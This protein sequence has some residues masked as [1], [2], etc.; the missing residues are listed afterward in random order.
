[1]EM[2]PPDL[3]DPAQRA[4]YRRELLG[5]ARPI[6]YLGVAMAVVGA[7]LLVIDATVTPL[8]KGL[9]WAVIG[10][11]FVLMLAA[12]AMRARYHNRRMRGH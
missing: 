8:P 11:A 9:P 2:A 3:S 4:A 6:R 1:M 10:A 12:I 7:T 5:I